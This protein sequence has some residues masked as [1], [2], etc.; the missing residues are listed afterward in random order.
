MPNT[1]SWAFTLRNISPWL[2]TGFQRTQGTSSR[3]K[4]VHLVSSSLT[5]QLVASWG[6]SALVIG[7]RRVRP[8]KSWL[9]AAIDTASD[10]ACGSSVVIW[11]LLVMW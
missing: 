11:M 5:I 7:L 6:S 9:M 4:K 2:V 1:T 3:R 10:A 8:R